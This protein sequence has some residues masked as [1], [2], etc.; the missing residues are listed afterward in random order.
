LP[1]LVWHP[2]PTLFALT[3]IPGLLAAI[4]LK[5]LPRAISLLIFRHEHS[6]GQTQIVMLK[7]VTA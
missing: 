7:G 4:R 6:L 1:P 2:Y 5:G 3:L